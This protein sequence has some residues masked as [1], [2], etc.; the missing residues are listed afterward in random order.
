MGFLLFG[1]GAFGF[2]MLSRA[3]NSSLNNS[4]NWVEHH[5]GRNF[6]LVGSYTHPQGNAPFARGE[7]IQIFKFNKDTGAMKLHKNVSMSGTNPTFLA[8]NP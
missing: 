1:M 6:A 4:N 3:D 7:G 8:I 2:G 5:D